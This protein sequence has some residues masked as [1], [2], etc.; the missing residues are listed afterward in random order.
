MR[1]YE[2]VDVILH[3]DIHLGTRFEDHIT[4]ERCKVLSETQTG[5]R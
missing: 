1:Y 4:T 3:M 5:L 2:L